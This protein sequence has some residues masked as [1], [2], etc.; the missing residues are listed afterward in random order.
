MNVRV[1]AGACLGLALL[2]GPACSSDGGDDHYTQRPVAQGRPEI[3]ISA[4]NKEIAVGDTTTLTVNSR[5]TLGH[6]AD[7]EWTTTGGK[8]NT[9]E[10]GRIA[11]I[12]FPAPGVY[13]VTA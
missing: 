8:L 10:N 5:N 9:E 7:V 12:T 13:T 1:L 11:R 3:N 4:S 6:S 2:A